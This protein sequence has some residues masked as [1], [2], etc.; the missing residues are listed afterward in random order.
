V[1]LVEWPK[2]QGRGAATLP[3]EDGPL[4]ARP[5]AF[6][7]SGQQGPSAAETAAAG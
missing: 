5:P 2:Q 7:G 1:G 4:L 6:D 3:N